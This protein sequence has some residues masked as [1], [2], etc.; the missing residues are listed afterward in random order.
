M[1]GALCL[2]IIGSWRLNKGLMVEFRN[3][4]IQYQRMDLQSLKIIK[5]HPTN[6]IS[7]QTNKP[8][9]QMSQEFKLSPPFFGEN[10]NSFEVCISSFKVMNFH[11]I[12]N[13]G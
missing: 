5:Y 4:T 2:R 13:L 7:F 8:E 1:N 9:K 3:S 12:N 11:R 10:F 6:F